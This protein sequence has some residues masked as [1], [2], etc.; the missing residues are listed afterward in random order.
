MSKRKSSVAPD[1]CPQ[2]GDRIG[3]LVVLGVKPC[4][5]GTS[6]TVKCDCGTEKRLGLNPIR[7]GAKSCGCL[8]RD[9]AARRRATQKR[10]RWSGITADFRPEYNTWRAMVSRCTKPLDVA[11]EHYG[12]R[13]IAICPRWKQSFIAFLKD[14]G[15][16]PTKQ[17]TL[18]RL[19]ND[20]DYEPNNC[21]WATRA[22]QSRNRRANHMIVVN[23]KSLTITDAA[24]AIGMNRSTLAN[25]LHQG[26][27]ADQAIF[28]PTQVK[29]RNTS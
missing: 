27:M 28:T 18:E 9:S 16:R 14:M 24:A 8:F 2:V 1:E 6:L 23:G 5:R 21:K 17:H 15:P 12:G 7:A 3:R 13:G 25:R 26:W 4:G 29:Y 20:G 22:E 10:C 19:D 11:Y